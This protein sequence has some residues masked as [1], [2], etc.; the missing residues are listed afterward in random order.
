MPPP[1]SND[2]G[3]SIAPRRLRLITWPCDLDFWPWMSCRL[4]LI[5]VVVLHSYTKFE[6]CR[7]C[8]SED[9]AHDVVWALVGLETLTFDLLTLKLVCKSHQRWEAFFPNLGTL[10]LW[11]LELFA[12]C[13]TDGQTDGRTKATLI[14]RTTKMTIQSCIAWPMSFLIFVA[15]C[16]A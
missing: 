10:G 14:A 9:M 6:V 2:I 3:Y 16:Y 15:R 7:P 4:W 1:G 12:M 5:R 11:V 8:R 13:A